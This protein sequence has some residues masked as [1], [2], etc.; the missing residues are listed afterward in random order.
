MSLPR[1]HER[2]RGAVAIIVGLM[3]VVLVGFIGLA[4]D[5][6]KL[7]VSKSELQNRAD[8]CALAAARDLTG[9][10]PLTVS[11][12]AGLTAAARNLVLFRATWNSS[13]TSHR[14]NP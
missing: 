1:I 13:R 10:T 3:I 6:G 8:S 14:P 4:L 2:Q 9:A 11:E 7:Y 12:A 5:L